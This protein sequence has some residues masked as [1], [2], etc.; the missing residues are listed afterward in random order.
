M[1]VGYGVMDHSLRFADCEI[2][3]HV[4]GD[5]DQ[6]AMAWWDSPD[7]TGPSIEGKMAWSKWR[8][9]GLFLKPGRNCL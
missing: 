8:G 1:L 7:S 4:L 6:D 3:S 5:L 9:L 2:P